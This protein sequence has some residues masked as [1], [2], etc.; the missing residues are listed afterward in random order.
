LNFLAGG[1]NYTLFVWLDNYSGLLATKSASGKTPDIPP[2]A[3]V[4]ITSSRAPTASEKTYIIGAIS[5]LTGFPTS[6][7]T[8]LCRSIKKKTRHYHIFCCCW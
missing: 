3:I 1:T 8:P 6:R 2:P 4:S 7:I 5:I